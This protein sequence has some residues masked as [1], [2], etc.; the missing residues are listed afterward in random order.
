MT[1]P[2][3]IAVLKDI[4]VAIAAGIA[5]VVAIKGLSTWNRELKGKATFDVARAL[6]KATFKLRDEIKN[7]RSPFL[8]ASEFPEG[9][10]SRGTTSY[11][12]EADALSHV[13][14]GRWGGVWDALQ[15]FDAI[16]LEAEAIFGSE[17]REKTDVL[18]GC[19]QELRAAIDA[20]IDDAAAQGQT[21]A[22]DRDFG[23]QMRGKVSTASGKDN[24][25]TIQIESAIKGI[26]SVIRPHLKRG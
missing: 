3:C 24:S 15:D 18:R 11:R 16:T 10:A 20:V 9:Y 8:A 7:C 17:I 23:R 1:I 22:S 2:E 21:F 25:L 26:E 4:V 13:Y 6:A 14:R 19:V 12:E 5:A